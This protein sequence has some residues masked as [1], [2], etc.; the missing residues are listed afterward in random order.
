[1]GKTIY[2]LSN[3]SP[4]EFPDNTLTTFG[5]KFP[6]LFD[7]HELAKDFKFHIALEAIGF[8]LNFERQFLPKSE[9][10]P[11]IILIFKTDQKQPSLCYSLQDGFNHYCDTDFLDGFLLPFDYNKTSTF[12]YLFLHSEDLTIE[13]LSKFFLTLQEKLKITVLYNAEK[14]RIRLLPTGEKILV[15]I[16][17]NL[18]EHIDVSQVYNNVIGNIKQQKFIYS[19]EEHEVREQTARTI[20]DDLYYDFRLEPT[21]SEIE[22]N[23]QTLLK[24]KLPKL[25]KVQCDE[26]RDQIF[27]GQNSKDL[28]VFCP[29][30]T[31]EKKFFFHEFEAKTY[32]VL[33]NTILNRINFRLVDEKN[34]PLALKTGIPTI[35]KLNISAMDRGKKSFNVRVTS[36]NKEAFQNNT[37]ANFKVS[38]PQTLFLNSNWRVGLSSVNLPNVFNTFPKDSRIS[39]TYVPDNGT[40]LEKIERFIP[41]KRYT[42]KDLIEEIN[43]FLQQNA[44]KLDIGKAYESVPPRQ[45][46]KVFHLEILKHGT[47]TMDK[48]LSDVLGFSQNLPTNYNNTRVYFVFNE[49]MDSMNSLKLQYNFVADTPIDMDFFKPSYFMLY[50]NIVKP[51]A[52]SGEFLTILKIF[53]VNSSDD[54]YV[55]QEFKH[56]EY[57]ALNNYDI[58]EIEFH[59]RS[60]TGEYIDFDSKN[61]DL[62]I[63]NLHF[64]NYF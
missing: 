2:C 51:T 29:E 3:G 23:L 42:K 44:K 60:H 62:V 9:Q 18:L 57:L 7:Y 58:K 14:Q 54:V 36:T 22:I 46:D 5:N 40:K 55:I 39:F 1:M 12:C 33:Q 59:L 17:L 15:H 26:I 25:V 41:H 63:L 27:N 61:K 19:T 48:N 49:Q 24:P 47:I 4:S 56:R 28:M 16:N 50:A 37:R 10:D 34:E 30:I 20:N 13:A 8:S 38:L 31:K 11:S 35:L 52:V 43:F 64:S 53:P 45:H 32:C 6:F 21:K